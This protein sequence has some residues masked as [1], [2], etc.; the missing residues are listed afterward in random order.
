[1]NILS[2]FYKNVL[3]Y[4]EKSFLTQES[5]I[6]NW[7][8]KSYRAV[9]LEASSI[10][11]HLITFGIQK[12]DKI[13]F[14]ARNQPEWI[15]M[16]IAAMKL[17]CTSVFM[18]HNAPLRNIINIIN[19]IAPKLIFVC[20]YTLPLFQEAL[21]DIFVQIPLV[22][23]TSNNIN[24]N[25]PLIIYSDINKGFITDNPLELSNVDYLDKEWATIMY[26]SGTTGEP[27][28]VIHTYSNHYSNA[29]AI[30]EKC[31][32]KLHSSTLVILPLSH[33]FTLTGAVYV[34]ILVVGNL[35]FCKQNMNSD[36]LF[37]LHS[38]KIT[39]TI[40]PDIL[41]VVP[42]ILKMLQIKIETQLAQHNPLSYKFLCSFLYLLY[43]T[44]KVLKYY[45]K[46][47][48]KNL[49]FSVL[50][51]KIFGNNL[52][53]LIC[54]GAPLDK[55]V[56][57]FFWLL[58]Q[59]ILNSYGLTEA[60]LAVSM[61]CKTN[62]KIFTCGKIL[63]KVVIDV[64]SSEY[65][66]CEEIIVRSPSNMVGYYQNQEET[67]TML[68]KGWLHTGDL[69]YID[70]KGF[71]TITGRRKNI[72]IRSNGEKFDPT[73][74]EIEIK[75]FCPYIVETFFFIHL[76]LIIGLFI[77]DY[78]KIKTSSKQKIIKTIDIIY[79]RIKIDKTW[80]P[81]VTYLVDKRLFPL[82]TMLTHTHKLKR[83]TAFDWCIKAL[84][85]PLD[86]GYI[87]KNQS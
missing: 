79:N 86:E 37:L 46:Y 87:F 19:S 14:F 74:S 35:F 33:A 45:A 76:D 59:P 27:K 54:G 39:K 84:F 83:E 75:E 66:E 31:N 38:L 60:C 21:S 73:N 28:G 41:L 24:S 69:G 81:H 5:S 6:G 56:E 68:I 23:S 78:T 63:N 16:H 7:E 48:R 53:H 49:L 72:L 22:I 55:E 8:A 29:I 43:N 17:N 64:I 30:Q 1:M 67:N 61:N 65:H 18:P 57:I 15:I 51:K 71:L 4:P 13:L 70:K 32:F 26:T 58:G 40:N 47:E 62:Y 25:C 77:V 80:I 12:K 50:Q 42:A 3:E 34:G 82:E 85:S 52:S 36:S 44:K 20:N 2:I 9:N 10:A 11:Q